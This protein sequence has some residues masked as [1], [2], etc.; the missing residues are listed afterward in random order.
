MTT[1]EVFPTILAAIGARPPAGVVLDGFDMTDVIS[2]GKKS[3]RNE[4]FWQRRGDF[5]ARVGRHKFVDSSR[6]GGLFDLVNDIGERNDLSAEKPEV[7]EMVKG[8]LA[9]W[10]TQMR[11]AEPRGPFKDF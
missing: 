8:R 5:A 10:C 1:L 3:P 6:G 2:G 9:N 11:Q 7:L 4:M